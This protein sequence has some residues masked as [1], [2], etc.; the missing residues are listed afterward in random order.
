MAVR[1]LLRECLCGDVASSFSSRCSDSGS[2]DSGEHPYD[3]DQG[4]GYTSTVL[5][6]VQPPGDVGTL[7]HH[8]LHK[9]Y[10]LLLDIRHDWSRAEEGPM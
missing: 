7:R 5:D 10:T 6:V 1:R 9:C 4:N 3:S 8:I 2:S